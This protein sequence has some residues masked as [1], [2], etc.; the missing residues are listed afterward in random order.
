MYMDSEWTNSTDLSR[1]LPFLAI[2]IDRSVSHN[3]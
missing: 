1:I 2:P 3:D